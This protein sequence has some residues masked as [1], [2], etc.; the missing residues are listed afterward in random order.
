MSII[1]SQQR[2]WKTVFWATMKEHGESMA[3]NWFPQ[4]HESEWMIAIDFAVCCLRLFA[5]KSYLKHSIGGAATC[6][7]LPVY[8]PLTTHA[9]VILVGTWIRLGAMPFQVHSTDSNLEI[10]YY[11]YGHGLGYTLLLVHDRGIRNV[12]DGASVIQ[13][14]IDWPD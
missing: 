6:I 7:R 12:S 10:G 5:H 4:Y 13:R 3:E 8:A 2:S 14:A 1:V 11:G 9:N